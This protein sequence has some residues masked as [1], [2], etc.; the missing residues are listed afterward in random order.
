[1]KTAVDVAR[2]LVE[3][4]P[5]FVPKDAE[6]NTR[7]AQ[8]AAALNQTQLALRL[9]NGFHKRHPKSADIP[10]NYLLAARI[11]SERM[12]KDAEAKALLTQLKTAY[13]DH[14]LMGDIDA[15]LKII[16]TTPAKKP[17]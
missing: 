8:R 1:E 2:E 11:L 13:P 17:A 5:A 3:L 6:S 16:D 14:A 10:A 9:V 12:G 15:L 4:D 7:L